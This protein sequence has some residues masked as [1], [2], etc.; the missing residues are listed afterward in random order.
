MEEGWVL[1]M[2]ER[3]IELW[4]EGRRLWDLRR[5]GDGGY[6]AALDPLETVTSSTSPYHPSHLR[7]QDLCFP[8]PQNE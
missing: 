1:L 2:R 6:P 3:G 5:W 8:V 7:V 4:L